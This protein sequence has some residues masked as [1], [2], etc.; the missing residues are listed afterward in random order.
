ME[1]TTSPV[2]RVKE[3]SI[4]YI[5]NIKT[6]CRCEKRICFVQ[7]VSQPAELCAL[8]HMLVPGYLP[9]LAIA[10]SIQQTYDY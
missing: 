2:L 10:Q 5:I 9:H 6:K 8:W 1:Q 3:L 7:H 4:P